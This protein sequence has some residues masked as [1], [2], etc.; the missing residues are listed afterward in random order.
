MKSIILLMILL[1]F[2]LA[3]TSKQCKSACIS[4]HGSNVGGRVATN[5][6][7]G[8][9]GFDGDVDCTC[10]F[11]MQQCRNQNAC[12]NYCNSRRDAYKYCHYVN[13]MCFLH[14]GLIY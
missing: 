14:V 8:P 10:V 9:Y 13:G 5:N 11:P 3:V 2:T 12:N 7:K 6:D 4:D 1:P